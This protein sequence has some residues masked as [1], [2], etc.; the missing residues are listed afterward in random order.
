MDFQK[1]IDHY[2][3]EDNELKHILLT[4]SEA[5]ANKA[6]AIA[7][8]H[9]EL[10]I[11]LSFLREA[12]MLHDIGIIECNAPGIYCFGTQ[13]YICHGRIGAEMLRSLGYPRHAR[14]CERHTGTGLTKEDIIKRH[15]PLPH[16]D[17]TPETWEEKLICYADK[18]FSKTHTDREKTFEQAEHSLAKFGEEGV[19]LFRQWASIFTL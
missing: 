3:Q 6:L 17:F 11:D 16:Q 1:I 10:N 5:V 15:L 7:S 19:I 4:N 13:P 9:P 8:L 12:A 14:V 2:Y 18:F